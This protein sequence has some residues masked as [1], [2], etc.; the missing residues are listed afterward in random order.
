M[1]LERPEPGSSMNEAEMESYRDGFMAHLAQ[2]VP[3]RKEL[4]VEQARGCTIKMADGHLYLDFISG[5]AVA[6]IGHSHPKVVA[7]VQEQMAN[8]AHVNVYGRFALPPQVEIAERLAR[9]APGDLDVAFLTSTGTEAIEGSLKLARKYTGRKRFIA[10]ER[11]FHGRTFGALSVSWKPAYREPFEPLLEGVDFVPFDDLDAVAAIIGDD[12]A[13]VIIEPIQGEGGVR[14]PSDD[15]LPGLRKLCDDAG[16]LLIFD[17]VQGAMGRTGHWFSFQLWD[18]VPDIVV[19]AKAFGGGLPLG[20][21]L[22][23]SDI[24]STFLDPPLSHLTTFGGNP[25]ACAAAVAAFDVIEE[26][27]LLAAAQQKGIEL[28]R[29]LETTMEQFPEFISDVRGRGLWLAIDLPPD[30]SM[31]IV[32]E[33]ERRGVIVGAMLSSDGTVRIAPP[34]TVAEAEL[35][36]FIGVLRSSL[37]AAR[38]GKLPE[39]ADDSDT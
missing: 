3:G 16:A 6:N 12:T 36:V 27:D 13:A 37:L 9:V 14:V 1:G 33:M 30:L 28:K 10:F 2:T 39:Q 11:G 21:F 24:F 19:L 8:Y 17:E 29:R 34:L 25:V 26:E 20:A 15:F 5:I 31:P 38:A 22:S 7:A 18:V 32:R 4:V 23:T 35:D